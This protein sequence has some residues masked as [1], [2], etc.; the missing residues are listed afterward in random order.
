M[1]TNQDYSHV[2]PFTSEIIS[3]FGLEK[4]MFGSDWPVCLSVCG[5][6]EVIKLANEITFEFSMTEK[7]KFFFENG[8]NFYLN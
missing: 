2:K 4:I 8:I 5:Y 7:Q 3:S 1:S 6:K